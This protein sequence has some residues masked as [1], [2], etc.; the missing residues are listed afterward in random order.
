[1]ARFWASIMSALENRVELLE[2]MFQLWADRLNRSETEAMRLE[3]MR[4]RQSDRISELENTNQPLSV[5]KVLRKMKKRIRAL[6][7]KLQPTD[8]GEQ[9]TEKSTTPTCESTESEPLIHSHIT[10]VLPEDHPLA[11]V[12]VH[13]W[14]CKEMVHAGNNECMQTW[15]EYQ[16]RFW[17]GTCFGRHLIDSDGVLPARVSPTKEGVD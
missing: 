17:C 1:M 3:M 14:N 10:D 5:W 16:R 12:Q 6:E 7:D 13:C 9:R 2:N 11:N 15:A 8:A 4:R